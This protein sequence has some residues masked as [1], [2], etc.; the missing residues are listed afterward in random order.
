MDI[1]AEQLANQIRQIVDTPIFQKV[2][3]KLKA[4]GISLDMAGEVMRYYEAGFE[5]GR[6]SNKNTET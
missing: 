3:D 4:S 6:R 2:K 1:T 5:D